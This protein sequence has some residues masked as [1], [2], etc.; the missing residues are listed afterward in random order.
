MDNKV[1]IIGNHPICADL[2][3]QFDQRGDIVELIKDVCGLK[4][5]RINSFKEVCLLADADKPPY[6]SDNEIMGVL[7]QIATGY[8]PERN[9]GKRILCHLLL[10]SQAFLHMIHL[11]GFR[12][13]IVNKLEVYPFTTDEQWSRKVALKL[14]RSPIMIQSNQTIHLVIFGMSQEAE[15]VA[16]NAAHVA[17]FPNY[18]RNHTLRTRITIVDE[19]ADEKA[20]IWIQKYK[21]LFDNCHYRFINPRKNPAVTNKVSPQYNEREEF[22]DIEWEFVSSSPYNRLLQQKIGQWAVSPSQL[23]TIVVVNSDEEKSLNDAL[24]LPDEIIENAIP[25]YVYMQSD[26]AFKQIHQSGKTVE[27]HPFGMVDEGYDINLPLVQMAKAVNYIYSQCRIM[28]GDDGIW[29]MEY[30]VEIDLDE[31]ERLWSKLPSNKRMSSIYN[32]MSIGVKMHSLGLKEEEWEKFYDVSQEEIELLA[33]VE[34]NRWS[35]EEL[36]L[37]WRPCNDREQQ[38]VES[39]ITKKEEL[40]KHKIHYDLRAYNDL[41]PDASGKPVEIYDRCLSACIPL[42]AKESKRR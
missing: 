25:V 31:K 9:N 13:E 32:A 34:H 37:G 14:D 11:E 3:R 41:R 10:R 42:I 36:I 28:E 20:L 23:L 17:H 1:L 19:K 6:E 12:E 15:L 33:Q 27:I 24:H 4:D 22:V 2:I 5:L 16:I 30:A 26:K 29:K 35:V 8:E 21:S 40:K 38:E 7:E 18:I 39:D